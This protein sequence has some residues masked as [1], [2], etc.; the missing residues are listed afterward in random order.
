M[1]WGSEFVYFSSGEEEEEIVVGNVSSEDE[2]DHDDEETCLLDILDTAGQEEY[3]ALRDQYTRTGDC[4]L[5]IY[6]VTEKGT[7]KDVESLYEFLKRVKGEDK[8]P[9]V[10]VGNKIDLDTE[11]QVTTQE[12]Q[13]LAA[14][15]GVAFIETSAKTGQNITSAFETLIRVTPRSGMDYKVVVLGSGGVGKSSITVRYTSNQFVDCYDP[16]IE[17][18]Y[19]KH[20]VISGIPDHL[21][22][23]TKKAAKKAAKKTTS[24]NKEKNI[25]RKSSG[26]FGSIRRALGM[27][28]DGEKPEAQQQA[29][30]GCSGDEDGYECHL[31]KVAERKKVRKADAN[32]LLLKMDILENEPQVVTGDPTYCKSCRAILSSTSTLEKPEGSDQSTW[33]CEFCDNKNDNLDISPEEI[34]KGDSFDFVLSPARVEVEGGEEGAKG[35]TTPEKKEE[36]KGMVVYCMDISGSMSA[37]VQLPTLQAEWRNARD[38]TQHTDNHVSR[39]K[40]IQDAVRRQLD[41]MKIEYPNKKVALVTFGSTVYLWGDCHDNQVKSYS[42][43]RMLEDF[44]ALVAAG[45]EY[46]T[47]MEL[48]GLENTFGN[49]DAKIDHLVT[50]G[51][52]ALGPALAISAGIIADIPHSEVVLCTDGEPNVGIGQPSRDGSDFYRRIGEFAKRNNT[53][54]SVLA[55]E[56]ADTGLRHV[57]EC[58]IVSGGTVNV[59][60]PLEMMRQLRLIA[61]NYTIATAVDVVVILHPDLVFDEPGFQQASN[62]L[63]KE[64]GNAAKETDLTFR[65]KSKDPKKKIS[66][67]TIPFQVQIS[68][69]LKNGMRCLR[70]LS[71]SHQ[72]TQDRKQMEENINVA[73]VGIAAVQ[74]SAVIASKGDAK[75]AQEHI[76]S[77]QKMITRGASKPTQMEERLAFKTESDLLRQEIR[78][79]VDHDDM[80]SRSDGRTN[81]FYQNAMYPSNK[82]RGS[83]TDQ[84]QKQTKSR[85]SEDAALVKQYQGYMC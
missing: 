51:S 3:S 30:S 68:Y 16:T 25:R 31:E 8:I 38:R 5:L 27:K 10:L 39:L 34:P 58:A 24:S 59:L 15:L 9:T 26:L 65:Y 53:R 64:V 52:T 61:Q 71:K 69:T 81:V 78:Q 35:E 63:V 66:K 36:S 6:S 40:A 84:K 28:T 7:F 1:E 19:R 11:R 32:V 47:S 23:A 21:K 82:Y 14:R 43:S 45:R 79:A 60:N 76:R 4:F 44:D 48:S 46:A 50:E 83:S 62:R 17:D 74:K 85:R 49:I 20:V 77:V 33:I 37:V 29:S 73:V 72:V 54:L 57:Q 56:G 41:R 80:E 13:D 75:K 42:D 22:K 12:G 55:V 67:K 18:S 2:M 70:V